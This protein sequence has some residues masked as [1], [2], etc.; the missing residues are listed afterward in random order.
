MGFKLNV[1]RF[2]HLIAITAVCLLLLGSSVKLDAAEGG[3][4]NYVPGTY[5]DFGMAMAPTEKWTLRNDLYYYK[6][7]TS[8]A[9]SSGQL[10]EDL[11][12]D[13]FN[14]FTTVLYM[15][16]IELFGA[17]YVTGVFVPMVIN[18]KISANIS[19]DGQQRGEKD[20]SSGLG[21]VILIPFTFYWQKKNFYWTVS[22]FIVTPTSDY[23]VNSAMNNG[24]NH[25]SIDTNFALE[26]LNQKTGWDLAFNLGHIYNTKNYATDYRTGQE[27]H[28]D[29]VVNKSLSKSFTVGLQ[30]FALK[31]ITGDNG[32]GATLGSFEGEAVGIGPALM[33]NTKIGKQ[34]ITFITKWIHEV[35]AEHRLKGDHV[36]LSFVLDW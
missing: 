20:S 4:S 5:G 6:A 8:R 15:P 28:L 31:Q 1:L 7:E 32:S 29:F 26:Y 3:Y 25:W 14:N 13:F 19:L 18:N 11:E 23:D 27:L 33:W 30:G 35:H 9:L 12:L 22:Q 36:F 21:D 34:D 24:L 17:K 2:W 10:R 16:D